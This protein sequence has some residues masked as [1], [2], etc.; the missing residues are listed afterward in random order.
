MKAAHWC[1][2]SWVGRDPGPE[3]GTWGGLSPRPGRS[4]ELSRFQTS[5]SDI[6]GSR[7]S[8]PGKPEQLRSAIDSHDVLLVTWIDAR[9]LA[10]G[11]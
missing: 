5:M 6:Y 10:L 11:F 1:G 8:A 2:G 3:A 4:R 7:R 9:R